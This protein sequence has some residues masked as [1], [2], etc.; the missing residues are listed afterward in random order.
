MQT[1]RSECLNPSEIQ[2]RRD[3]WERF[4][5]TLYVL[6]S[7]QSLVRYSI[8]FYTLF[9]SSL[10]TGAG[11][12]IEQNNALY[13]TV[14]DL[15]KAL[16][17]VCKGGLWKILKVWVPRKNHYHAASVSWR[18]TGQL[19]IMVAYHPPLLSRIVWNMASLSCSRQWCLV[20]QFPSTRHRHKS[21]NRCEPHFFSLLCVY[22]A[23]D[24]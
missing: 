14:V 21:Q 17:T 15:T 8:L 10:Q 5:L 7:Q 22:P 11:K 4:F 18:N 23:R 13:M 12:C 2:V 9:F 19:K 20:I 6:Y 24:G 1:K 3:P 16:V